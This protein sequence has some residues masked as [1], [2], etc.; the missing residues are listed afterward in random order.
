MKKLIIITFLLLVSIDNYAQSDSPVGKWIMIEHLV[1]DEF[2]DE[3]N[4]WTE[5]NIYHNEF[6]N[7]MEF[8]PDGF[9]KQIIGDSLIIGRWKLSSN[10]KKLSIIIKDGENWSAKFKHPIDFS[11]PILKGEKL[12]ILYTTYQDKTWGGNSKFI[13]IEK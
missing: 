10:R 4:D 13:R 11:K 7:I 9:F 1:S 12:Y 8:K 3:T 5:K 2:I 6:K